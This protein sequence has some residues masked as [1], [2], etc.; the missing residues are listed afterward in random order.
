MTTANTV[1]PQS[2]PQYPLYKYTFNVE[3][4]AFDSAHMLVKYTP[5]NT[6]L[7]S[8]SLSLP[9]LPTFDPANLETYVDFWAPRAQWFGQE[10][11]LQ[12]ADALIGAN[13]NITVV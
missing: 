4:F 12:H 3:N 2:L 5:V 10:I 9:I 7:T 1:T 6:Q 13:S 11:I 8:I